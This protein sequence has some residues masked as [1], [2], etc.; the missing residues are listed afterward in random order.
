MGATHDEPPAV[1]RQR[2]RRVLR[3]ARLSTGL[4]QGDVASRL[5]WSLSKVQ[6]IESGEVGVSVTDLR[7]LLQVYGVEDNTAV[8]QLVRDAAIS[9]RQRWWIPP[10]YR[11]HLT[12][13]LRQLLQF[14]AEAT[15][16]R[17]YQ[18][19]I[20]PGVLQTPAMAEHLLGHFDKSLTEEDRKVRFDVRM[21]R[22]KR[23]TGAD[24]APTY[25]LM[26]DEA[27]IKRETGGRAVMAEQLEAVADAA[28][29]PNVHIRIVKLAQGVPMG[30]MGAFVVLDLTDDDS[31]DAVL[32]REAYATDSVT[33]DVDTVAYY[34]AAFEAMWPRCYDQADSLRLIRAEAAALRAA[35][36]RDP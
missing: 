29:L 9:R 25:L 24:D 36:I 23:I 34:R 4:I 27:A 26:L 8:E 32:Y 31:E 19:F 11:D 35:L 12:Q 10:E 17:A 15:T 22:A 30:M 28:R 5:G 7:A 16:I 1:A 3:K 21:L 13:G 14:E 33:H 18:P 20:F 2:V 6:R